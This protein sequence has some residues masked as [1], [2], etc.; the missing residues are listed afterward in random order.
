MY[1]SNNQEK[2]LEDAIVHAL[3]VAPRAGRA[4]GALNHLYDARLRRRSYSLCANLDAMA[5]F[6]SSDLDDLAALLEPVTA[7]IDKGWVEEIIPDENYVGGSWINHRL[8]NEAAD[9]RQTS[10]PLVALQSALIRVRN[11]LHAEQTAA[12][13]LSNSIG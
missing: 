5:M 4:L 6:R 1:N 8:T 13:L 3:S 9:L 11:L 7:A 10:A 2:S 12:H